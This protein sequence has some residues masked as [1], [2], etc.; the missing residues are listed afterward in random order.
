MDASQNAGGRARWDFPV[1]EH[2]PPKLKKQEHYEQKGF[3]KFVAKDWKIYSLQ[4]VKK[5][6]HL[7][8]NKKGKETTLPK[9]P[10]RKILQIKQ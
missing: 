3:E 5:E 8:V 1:F 10:R 9:S 6:Q 7:A 4:S 2:N